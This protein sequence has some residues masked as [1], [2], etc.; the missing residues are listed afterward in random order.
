M[1]KQTTIKSKFKK[2]WKHYL[3]QSLLAAIVL[4]ILVLVLGRCLTALA[5]IENPVFFMGERE[6][7]CAECAK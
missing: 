4:F 7:V 5:D 3:L 6:G 2:L 1:V